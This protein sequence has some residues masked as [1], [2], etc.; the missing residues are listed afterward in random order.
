MYGFCKVHKQEVD[1]CPQFQPIF[2]ASKTP[3]YNLAMCL[4]SIFIPWTKN[5][6]KVKDS[7][8]FTDEIC[9]EDFRCS[10]NVDSLFT[11]I[12]LDE[13]IDIFVNQL[14]ENTDTVDGF[15]KSELKQILCLALKESYLIFIGLL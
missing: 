11:K 6:C 1:N 2:L 15:T 5:K 14:F 8:Y 9:E 10:L 12:P 4:V 13:T 3:T 7:F